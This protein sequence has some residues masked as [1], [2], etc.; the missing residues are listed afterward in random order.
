MRLAVS[1]VD[2]GMQVGYLAQHPL[3]EQIPELQADIVEPEYCALGEG[4]LQSI[5]AWLGPAGMVS[6]WTPPPLLAPEIS[7][8]HVEEH[9]GKSL[10]RSYKYVEVM[11]HSRLVYHQKTI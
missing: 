4:K 8:P 11:T 7:Y 9:P 6:H 2:M 5:N 10:A 1:E 3:F